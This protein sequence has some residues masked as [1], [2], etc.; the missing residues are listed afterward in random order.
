[1]EGFFL[2]WQRRLGAEVPLDSGETPL[3]QHI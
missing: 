1:M 3:L 2:S